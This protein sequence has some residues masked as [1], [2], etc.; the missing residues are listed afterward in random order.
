MEEEQKEE[1]EEIAEE[2][3]IENTEDIDE[4]EEVR[5]DSEN[6]EEIEKIVQELVEKATPE[7][8]VEAAL[9]ISAKFVSVEELVM[10]TSVSPL[11]VKESLFK[12]RD[13]YENSDGALTLIEKENNWKMDVKPDY[14][15]IVSK[16]ATGK[17]EFSRAEQETLAII[18]YK[19]PIK[20]SIVVKIRGNKAYEHVKRFI[21][22]G[23]VKAKKI[24][25]T[26]ELTLSQEFYDY[27]QLDKESIVE[28]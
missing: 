7:K 25:H 28:K 16:L 5:D 21:E 24:S 23:L 1:I 2:E 9:F 15:N 8:K 26:S 17:S 18:A 19:Q 11:L 12:L 10:L 27:F 13:K 20:Q 22:F 3:T 14:K 6:T 4:S